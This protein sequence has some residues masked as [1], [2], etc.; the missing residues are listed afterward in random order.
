VNARRVA[1]VKTGALFISFISF[2]LLKKTKGQLAANTSKK[3]QNKND[4]TNANG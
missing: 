1:I 2:H 4:Q 3:I